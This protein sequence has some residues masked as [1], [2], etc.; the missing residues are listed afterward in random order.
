MQVIE[1][2]EKTYFPGKDKQEVM[3]Q[4]VYNIHIYKYTAQSDEL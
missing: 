3:L 2:E 4:A 1:R